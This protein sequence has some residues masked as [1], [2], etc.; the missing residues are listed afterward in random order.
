MK[1][2]QFTQLFFSFLT[3]ALVVGAFLVLPLNLRGDD[4]V[5]GDSPQKTGP[6]KELI[7]SQIERAKT[8]LAT[9]TFDL[10]YKFKKGERVRAKIASS[11]TMSTKIRGTKETARTKSSSVR[12]WSIESVDREGNISFIHSIESVEMWKQVGDRA[13][14]RYSSEKDTRAPIEYESVAKTI[15]VPLA[16]ITIS[17]VG[18]VVLRSDKQAAFQSS[19]GDLTII[20]PH[21]PVKI[22]EEWKV[23]EELKVPLEIDQRVEIRRIQTRQVYKLTAVDGGIATITQETEILTPINDP[24]LEAKL[25]QRVKQGT[26]KFDIAAGRVKSRTMALNKT[27]VNFSGAGSVMQYVARIDEQLVNDGKVVTE[28]DQPQPGTARLNRED[29]PL[30]RR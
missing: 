12:L 18:R 1:S 19:V 26:I 24:K 10:Q 25:V 30:L 4:K 2:T 6:S 14:V 20:L 3:S 7:D 8:R 15:G 17:P 9:E 27:V 28:T 21:R 29:K 5:G 23:T 13:E 22:G 16:T 11:V